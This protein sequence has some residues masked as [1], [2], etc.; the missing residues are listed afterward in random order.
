MRFF[1]CTLIWI[2]IVGGLWMYTWHRDAGRPDGPSEVKAVERIEGS[3]LLEI[4]PTFSIE[5]DPFALQSDTRVTA[6]LEL[7]LNGRPLGVPAVE[8]S[9]GKVIQIQDLPDMQA[10]FNEFYISAAPPI[11]ENMM[12]HGLRIKLSE[13]DTV[14]IDKTLWGSRGARVSGA[15]NFKLA[16]KEEKPHEH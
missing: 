14:I 7:R 4:T 11:M 1:L 13:G 5:K 15:V 3:Y 10:G 6:S 12:D 16:S 9:R 8:M 2:I